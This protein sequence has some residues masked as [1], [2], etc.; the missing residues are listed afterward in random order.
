MLVVVCSYRAA[1]LLST[2]RRYGGGLN[3]Y[4]ELPAGGSGEDEHTAYIRPGV[5]R[6]EGILVWYAPAF[7]WSATHREKWHGEHR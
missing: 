1:T 5:P 6:T 4:G 3:R 7:S 2:L